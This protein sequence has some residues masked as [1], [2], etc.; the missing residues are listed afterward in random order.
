[1]AWTWTSVSNFFSGVYFLAYT[2]SIV[3]FEYARYK[4]KGCTRWLASE[5][6]V[7]DPFVTM[8][9]NIAVR[10]SKKN[11]YYTKLFQA[12]AYSSEIYDDALASF[13]IQYTDTVDYDES[14]Y[15]SAYLKQVVNHA[16]ELGYALEINRSR[17]D[18]RDC[19]VDTDTYTPSKTGSVSLIFY[20]TLSN[21]MNGSESE[22]GPANS[23]RPVV[24]KYLRANMLERIQK[25]IN[26]FWYMIVV[27]DMFPQFKHL[28]LKDVFNEQKTMM[29]SQVNFH[30]EVENIKKMY[31]N[32]ERTG[33]T[34]V[35]I[36]RVYSEFT[37]K[38][39]DI[40][41][42]ERLSGKKLEELSHEEKDEYCSIVAKGLIK[43]VFLDGFYHCDMHPGNLLFMD[44]ENGPC[45]PPFKQV[46]VFDF[47]IMSN[48][49]VSEQNLSFDLFKF[50]LRKDAV[51]VTRTIIVD[52]TEPY[53]SKKEKTESKL[54][55]LYCQIETLV[56]GILK[57]KPVTCFSAKEL[58]QL[59]YLLLPYNL[60][61]SGA[62]TKFEI[63]LS[64]C[65]NLCK[66]LAV[67]RTYMSY[68]KDIVDDM[69]FD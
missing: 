65:D 54:D 69:M 59:N 36:P 10:L 15:S 52:Y 47:G 50:I 11:V 48:I 28:H 55:E 12:I 58:C 46:G 2:A 4:T 13:F 43:S 64:V 27:L 6:F 57:D 51:E 56:V 63:S 29:L 41:I 45:G 62:L 7:E 61:I 24:I 16:H 25:S 40:I 21:K 20:G 42:M 5:D 67:H 31:R 26:D 9:K 34:F 39:G 37:T 38:F 32:Y 49:S 18:D 17:D 8:V 19:R 53:D 23:P 60:K 22:F 35:K 66:K 30:T 33:T 68:L 14:E 1:M 44:N 3:S